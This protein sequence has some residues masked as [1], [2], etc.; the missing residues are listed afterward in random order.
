[1]GGA[2]R[3][4]YAADPT[5]T[6]LLQILAHGSQMQTGEGLMF[7]HGFISAYTDDEIAALANYTSSQFGNGP[8]HVTAKDVRKCGH[9]ARAGKILSASHQRGS[10]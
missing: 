10:R 5:A 3:R 2:E 7:M 4:T 6:N 8:G 1:M 9:A